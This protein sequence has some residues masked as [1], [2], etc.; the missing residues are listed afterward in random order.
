MKTT[1]R[2]TLS[3]LGALF[4][5]AMFSVACG[6]DDDWR[7]RSVYSVSELQSA[8][9]QPGEVQIPSGTQLVVNAQMTVQSDETLFVREGASIAGDGKLD[10]NG[11]LVIE[12]QADL[13]RI[14]VNSGAVVQNTGFLDVDDLDLNGGQIENS[15]R[16]R[17]DDLVLNGGSA[18][19][20]TG[21]VILE[22]LVLNGG[23][24][25]NLGEFVVSDDLTLNGGSRIDNGSLQADAAASGSVSFTVRDQ[26]TMNGGLIW[27]SAR[28]ALRLNH[29]TMHGGSQIDN[30]AGGT[31]AI[32]GR[33]DVQVETTGWR[34]P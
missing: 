31:V 30:A 18:L 33:C 29:V 12:G 19:V 28:G 13:D 9:G 4:A 2:N 15:G 8:L 26:L 20:N 32:T 11:T 34:C 7:G 24:L 3:M 27:N 14:S 10:V 16:L 6:D 17:T 21:R 22:E 1:K 23:A 5:A 25:T